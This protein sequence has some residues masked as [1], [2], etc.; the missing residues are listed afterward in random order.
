M[1][2]TKKQYFF[3]AVS[4]SILMSLAFLSIPAY[5]V[6]PESPAKSVNLDITGV[7]YVE[8]KDT[9]NGEQPTIYTVTEDMKLKDILSKRG[10]SYSDYTSMSGKELT[11][12]EKVGVGDELK[13]FSKNIKTQTEDIN[14]D[15]PDV[16][17]KTDELYVGDTQT[18][19]EGAS[20]KATRI[21]VS[22]DSIDTEGK[23][24]T[25]TEETM[26]VKSKPVAKVV[27]EGTKPRPA[28]PSFTL[29][30]DSYSSSPY[31]NGDWVDSA[32]KQVGKPY[33]WGAAGPN[34]FDCSGLI[35]WTY[36]QRGISIPRT[37]YAQGAAGQQ[38]SWSEARR[39]DVVYTA[40]HIAFYLGDGKI[41]HAASPGSG[42][43]VSS[44]GWMIAQGA[45]VARLG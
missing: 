2:K 11:G 37:A 22:T 4:S 3:K 5:S 15:L 27:K 1:G 24:T 43:T 31:L 32:L 17:E 28:M 16:V 19:V 21:T 44:V 29:A 45:K 26:V 13:I 36:L 10:L 20:G 6:L 7:V 9:F 38:I 14:I 34:A 40:G 30:G 12:D 18:V 42:V 33:A 23:V 39:G 25:D 35:Y 8:N 41:V